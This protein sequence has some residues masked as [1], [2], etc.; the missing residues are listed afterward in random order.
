ML[1]LFKHVHYPNFLLSSSD[2]LSVTLMS[3]SKKTLEMS[4]D[5]TPLFKTSVDA[6]VEDLVSNVD[7]L[8]WYINFI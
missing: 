8:K 4:F 3:K 1:N 2:L 7:Y 6:R 5:P